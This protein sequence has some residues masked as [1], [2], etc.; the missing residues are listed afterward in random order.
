MSNSEPEAKWPNRRL[1]A[2]ARRFPVGGALTAVFLA[3]SPFSGFLYRNRELVSAADLWRYVVL[4]VG[5]LL[6][7]VVGISLVFWQ[8][9]RASCRER[10]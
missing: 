10:V 2:M 1:R 6:A 5:A 7:V 4:Y 3:A 9:G 8:I